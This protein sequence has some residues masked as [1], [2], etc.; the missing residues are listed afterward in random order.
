MADGVLG[1]NDWRS[2]F[3]VFG[4]ARSVVARLKA[5]EE[6]TQSHLPT[7]MSALTGDRR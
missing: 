4:L 7:L 3:L 5:R 6:V 1:N 2:W